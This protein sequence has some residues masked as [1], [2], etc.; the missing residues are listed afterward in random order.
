MK[1]T[2]L[3]PKCDGNRILYIH[4]VADANNHY[5]RWKPMLLAFCRPD[6][7]T[8]SNDS[9][10]EAVGELS[11]GVCRACG[12][13]EFYVKNPEAIEPDGEFIKELVGP[14]RGNPYRG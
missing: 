2:L 11:A 10:A 7:R 12:Y 3:C 13:T 4:R 1:K 5:D 8:H 14:P 9:S 6:W